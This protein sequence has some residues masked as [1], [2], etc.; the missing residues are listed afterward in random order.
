MA[1]DPPE[2]RQRYMALHP[3][4]R[5]GCNPAFS[6]RPHPPVPEDRTR[7][8]MAGAG[9]WDGPWARP[10]WCSVRMLTRRVCRSSVSFGVGDGRL[11][12]GRGTSGAVGAALSGPR[13][14]R[15][16][17]QPSLFNRR[18]PGSCCA[19][20]TQVWDL[21]QTTVFWASPTPKQVIIIQPENGRERGTHQVIER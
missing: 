2:P 12:P 17:V 13:S 15:V 5:D 21:K 6:C 18:L 16:R 19:P 20:G 11:Q 14:V 8:G 1:R 9:P 3:G 7:T 10:C 4:G